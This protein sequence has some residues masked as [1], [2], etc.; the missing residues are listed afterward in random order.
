MRKSARLAVIILSAVSVGLMV[1]GFIVPPTGVIDG[2]VL[3]ACGLLAVFAALFVV[4][5]AIDKG[6]DAKIKH[7]DL[8]VELKND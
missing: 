4:T 7:K 8:S 1:A 5:Y 6:V 3:T 2:S